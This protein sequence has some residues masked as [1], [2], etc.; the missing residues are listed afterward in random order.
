MWLNTPHVFR[1]TCQVTIAPKRLAT[2]QRTHTRKPGLI[3]MLSCMGLNDV[4]VS[5]IGTQ[6]ATR[7]STCAVSW[8]LRGDGG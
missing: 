8:G 2:C 7:P 4:D 3:W 1:G 5:C 6:V